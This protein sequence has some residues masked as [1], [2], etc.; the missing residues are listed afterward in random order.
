MHLFPRELLLKES[1]GNFLLF[2]DLLLGESCIYLNELDR[3]ESAPPPQLASPLPF[4]LNRNVW[5]EG[6]QLG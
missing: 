6:R 5:E 3:S 1:H 2:R 4:A